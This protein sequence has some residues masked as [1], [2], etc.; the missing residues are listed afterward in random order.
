MK[1]VSVENVNGLF[2]SKITMSASMPAEIAPFVGMPNCFAIAV[3][4]TST[5]RFIEMRPS[6]TPCSHIRGR[7]CWIAAR[8]FGIFEKS[9]APSAFCGS[10]NGQ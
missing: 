4:Q 3:E 7:R 8:P 10:S 6:L 2:G 5:R 1:D 9:S